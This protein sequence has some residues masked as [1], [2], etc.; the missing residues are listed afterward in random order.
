LKVEKRGIGNKD[1]PPTQTW[2]KELYVKGKK[3][4]KCL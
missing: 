3:G 4:G 1:A 2:E